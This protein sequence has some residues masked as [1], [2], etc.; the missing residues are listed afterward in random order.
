MNKLVWIYGLIA[1]VLALAGCQAKEDNPN[2]PGK[3][4]QK[5]GMSDSSKDRELA[6]MFL[7]GAQ[8][9][10]KKMMYDATNLTAAIVDESREKLIRQAQ[11]KLNDQQR[12]ANENILRTS[13]EIDF[14]SGKIRKLFPKSADLQI[15]RTESIR[16]ESGIT[17]FD[18]TVTITYN[19]RTETFS[20]KTGQQVK[21]MTVHLQQATSTV[22]GRQINSFSFD[23]KGFDRFAD[24]DFDVLSYY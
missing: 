18:H 2:Q 11:Y 3:P 15:T 16:A 1:L 10:D 5:D 24:K 9:G 8:T 14:F 21:A 23:S 19:N 4:G 17:R 7:R 13:G 6:L 12:M 22:D 20:D